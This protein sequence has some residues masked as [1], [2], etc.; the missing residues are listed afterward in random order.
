MNISSIMSLYPHKI[1]QPQHQLLVP[2]ES[3][4]CTH[5][6]SSTIPGK[7]LSRCPKFSSC[8]QFTSD[9][10]RLKHIK[11][12]NPEHVQV[13]KNLTVDSAPRRIE[14]A[15]GCEFHANK[16]SVGD[17]DAFP[18]LEQIENVSDSESQTTTTSSTSDQMIPRCR[19][20]AKLLAC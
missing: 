20:S 17:L 9:S 14:R 16:D 3:E 18:Y 11:L 10:W 6:V 12:H 19:C 4:Y 5:S 2:I 15:Q 8:N 7:T 1:A 13:T